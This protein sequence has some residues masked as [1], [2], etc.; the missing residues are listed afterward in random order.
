M[1]QVTRYTILSKVRKL[2]Q[3]KR[4]QYVSGVGG[5]AIFNEHSV[6]W[7]IHLD[8][9][10]ESLYIGDSQPLDLAVGDEVKVTIEKVKS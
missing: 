10:R 8:G 4:K 6:G 9:S 7:Y 2:E 5:D 3:L 1:H